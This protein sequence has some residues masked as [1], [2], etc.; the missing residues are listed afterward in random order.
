MKRSY[1]MLSAALAGAMLVTAAPIS[2]SAASFSDTRNHWAESSVERWADYGT[3]QGSGGYFQPDA[4]MT[5]A[6]MAT[7]LTNLLGLHDTARNSFADVPAGSWYED[8]ILKCAAAGI[9]KGDGHGANP[10]SAITREEATVMLARAL[11]IEEATGSVTFAD[12]TQ[13]SNWSRGYIRAMV[14]KGIINGVGGNR[15][16]PLQ[17]IDR[18]AVVTILDRSI[19]T[20]A[21]RDDT[22]VSAT[23][24][25]ITLIAAED[26]TLT[27]RARGDV[28]VAPGARG[29]KL[30]LNGAEVDGTLR[31]QT[32]GVT[33]ALT[34]D[35]DVSKID[36][37][38]DDATID[39]GKNAKIRTINVSADDALI[40][41][42]GKVTQLNVLAG[43]D[44]AKITTSG[45][46]ISVD[47][48]AGKV[49]TRSGSVQPGRNGSSNGSSS[50]DDDDDDDTKYVTGISVAVDAD[51]KESSYGEQTNTTLG[52]EITLSGNR[53]SGTLKYQNELW[54]GGGNHYFIW[55]LSG[56][57]NGDTVTVTGDQTKTFTADSGSI[58]FLWAKNSNSIAITVARK[59]YV[60]YKTTLDLSGLV[61]MP[62]GVELP[63]FGTPDG[64]TATLDKTTVSGNTV[65]YDVTLSGTANLGSAPAGVN[66]AETFS[67]ENFLEG[68][69]NYA[70]ASILDPLPDDQTYT[71]K[72]SN[73]AFDALYTP[74][75]MLAE[76]VFFKENNKTYKEKAGYEK[77]GTTQYEF[78]LYQDS[79]KIEIK[80]KTVSET[81]AIYNINNQVK[82]R[83]NDATEANQYEKALNAHLVKIG[84]PGV[85]ASVTK[86]GNRYDINL[87][88]KAATGVPDIY[89]DDFVTS[90]FVEKPGNYA[91]ISLPMLL[92]QADGVTLRVEQTNNAIGSV[93]R[94][95]GN[96]LET[97]DAS[98]TKVGDQWVKAKDYTKAQNPDYDFLLQSGVPI[99][100]KT[101]SPGE[102]PVTTT[103]EI[104]N[105]LTFEAPFAASVIYVHDQDS[106]NKI[107]DESYVTMPD[108]L[109]TNPWFLIMLTRNV[110]VIDKNEKIK[111]DTIR[112]KIP[113]TT[114]TKA[115]SKIAT[116]QFGSWLTFYLKSPESI[117]NED[118]LGLTEIKNG[119]YVISFTFRGQTFTNEVTVSGYPE[120]QPPA[121]S[122]AP[123]P[124]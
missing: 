61:E 52:N 111:T 54:D 109:K 85:K 122:P 117:G 45:T 48:N 35:A 108:N 34:D 82:V 24:S 4:S 27:G 30:T 10:N 72:Q 113:D 67:P 50:S 69:K 91:V 87:S 14:D 88:G 121:P 55:K 23:G 68:A 76:S 78:L 103:Y 81:I 15:F 31:V 53:V 46:K 84:Y 99:T 39:V 73:D 26:V 6:E 75:S 63:K 116:A 107:P 13:V 93:Y 98:V 3:V 104:K 95:H 97:G 124:A 56:L 62:Q 40:K 112:V 25:G 70:S 123:L 9:L 2:A 83:D 65:T 12:G 5:R 32:S 86:T 33:L 49:A 59:D 90:Q 42:T 58:V 79:G 1:K 47:K 60:S 28:I 92:P 110:N 57:R 36:V 44:R 80:V 115:L 120:V 119:K 7:V 64:V 118:T 18:A 102:N 20:Y 66:F 74:E 38:E 8:A 89:K 16:A 22:T 94:T 41:G 21:N 19:S 100:I 105:S 11:G 106:Y 29:S 37:T 51:T 96:Q 114:E 71:I 101:I 77:N 17:N 43:A